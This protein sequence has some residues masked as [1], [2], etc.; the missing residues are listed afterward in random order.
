M[1]QTH[2]GSLIESLM[3]VAI[4]WGV[5]LISQIVLFP[6]FEIHIPLSSNLWLSAW[7]TVISIARSYVVRRWFN[8]RLHSIAQAMTR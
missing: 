6:M 4:G 8:S 1:Q 5:A 2:L 3:N 7:F